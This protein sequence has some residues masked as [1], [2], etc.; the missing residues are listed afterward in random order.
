M[1]RAFVL[2]AF[3]FVAVAHIGHAVGI[4]PNISASAPVGLWLDRPISSPLYRGMM[5]GVCP[6]PTVPLVKLFSTNGTLPYG[7]CA[8]TNVA[9]LLKP[10]RALPGDTVRISHGNPAMV[11]GI[12][13]S[14]TIAAKS[15]PAWPDG[16]YIVKPGEVWLFS[17]YN[18]RSF[19]SRYFGPVSISLI[20]GEAIPLLVN[21]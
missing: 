1:R 21:K 13:L 19:D 10:I 18:E 17:S 15:L 6:P 11:N 9:L 12:A 7:P 8:Q 14:N 4:R 5:I 20:Q 16:E 3:A 2:T